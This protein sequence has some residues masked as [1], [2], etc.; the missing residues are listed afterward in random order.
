MIRRGF[1]W[2]SLYRWTRT[3]KAWG[4]WVCEDGIVCGYEQG[5]DKT[6]TREPGH[7]CLGGG[8][9]LGVCVD[10]ACGVGF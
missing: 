1:G 5:M 8:P 9:V 4:Y 3:G 7:G 6:A 10:G 2:V